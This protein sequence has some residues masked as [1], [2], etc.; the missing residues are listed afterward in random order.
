METHSR[1]DRAG[2]TAHNWWLSATGLMVVVA[3]VQILMAAL[4]L[5]Q[6]FDEPNHLAAGIEWL[7]E[8]SYGLWPENPPLARAT[9]ALVPYLSGMRLDM[10]RLLKELPENATVSW[11]AGNDWLYGGGLE[12]YMSRLFRARLGTLVFFLIA[13]GVVWL[14]AY[15]D[16]GGLSAFLAVVLFC[17]IPPVLA[18]SAL[19]TTDVASS[20]LLLLAVYVFTWYL[21]SPSWASATCVGLSVGLAVTTKFSALLMLP[22]SMLCILVATFVPG[23]GRRLL[24][25]L[26]LS[27]WARQTCVA[28]VVGV[29]VVLTVYRCDFGRIEEEPFSSI[30][31][32]PLPAL[33]STVVPAPALFM[34]LHF[35]RLHNEAGHSAYALGEVSQHGFLHYYPLA[36]LVKTPLPTIALALACL[37]LLG[38]S[39]IRGRWEVAAPFLSVFA[40]LISVLPSNI[41]IGVRHILPVYPF[42]AIAVGIGMARFVSS[43]SGRRRSVALGTVLAV[44]LCQTAV[45]IG[46]HPRYLSFFNMLAGNDPGTVLV[47]SD[48]DWGQDLTGLETY[49]AGQDVPAL[50]LAYFG[51]ALPCKHELPSL[52]PLDPQEPSSGW[53]AISEGIY[54]GA[55]EPSDQDPCIGWAKGTKGGAFAWLRHHEPVHMIGRSIRVYHIE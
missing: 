32:T 21:R 23:S 51:S 15:R 27:M 55:F 6:T 29:C 25:A 26:T 44:V 18:H 9:T 31:G 4:S 13:T 7:Q 46:T 1:S 17:S 33:K 28:A 49:L 38:S 16:E 40:V 14:W 36:L 50:R 20:A 2:S 48:L 43:L 30:L 22:A 45:T 19:A 3:S 5:T 53:I 11:V 47:D 12:Q 54:R 37:Y 10:P 42:L 39:R 34:G 52:L 8:G 41:N 35:L 24:S